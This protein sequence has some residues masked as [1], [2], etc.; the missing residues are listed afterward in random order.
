MVGSSSKSGSAPSTSAF[1]CPVGRAARR[2]PRR[3]SG[4]RLIDRAALDQPLAGDRGNG[5]AVVDHA[6]EPIVGDA[7]TG[8]ALTPLLCRP[9][10]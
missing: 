5:D 4:L 10:E 9:P 2:P 7:P 3:I 8:V 6:E 1:G